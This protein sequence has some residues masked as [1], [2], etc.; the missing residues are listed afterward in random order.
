MDISHFVSFATIGQKKDL[1]L[2][3]HLLCSRN[4]TDRFAYIILFHPLVIPMRW[5]W[6]SFYTWGNWDS[7]KLNDL[8]K[9]TVKCEAFKTS[10]LWQQPLSFFHSNSYKSDRIIH[11]PVQNPSLSLHCPKE[12]SWPLGVVPKLSQSGPTLLSSALVAY[13]SHTKLWAFFWTVH[14]ASHFLN[15]LIY[16]CL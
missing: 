5:R 14:T 12:K 1:R 3:G 15:L 11:S 2:V 7:E 9:D 6:A 10:T 16:F 13:F 8:A 4:Y